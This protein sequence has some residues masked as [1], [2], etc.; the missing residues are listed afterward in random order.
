MSTE[1]YAQAPARPHQKHLFFLRDEKKFGLSTTTSGF[2][3]RVLTNRL[4][5]QSEGTNATACVMKAFYPTYGCCQ[6]SLP[7][8]SLHC[9]DGDVSFVVMSVGCVSFCACWKLP[10]FETT[11][12]LKRPV[13]IVRARAPGLVFYSKKMFRCSTCTCVHY[14]WRKEFSMKWISCEQ[15]SFVCT[16]VPYIHEKG[17]LEQRSETVSFPCQ[18]QDCACSR[19]ELS[20]R[21]ISHPGNNFIPTK[22]LYIRCYRSGGSDPRLCHCP[23]SVVRAIL[24]GAVRTFWYIPSACR[25]TIHR[26]MYG[27]LWSL[28]GVG[29]SP[30]FSSPS[31]IFF[32]AM[33]RYAKPKPRAANHRMVKEI[34]NFLPDPKNNKRKSGEPKRK[35]DKQGKI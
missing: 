6:M 13:R 35:K 26:R 4:K 9:C 28:S 18:T 3:F 11:R 29:G 24:I 16:K 34:G 10:F 8:C 7:S 31:H 27:V 22:L 5:E 30:K 17:L 15:N 21:W 12:G 32:H 1:K 19:Q 23:G 20:T 33:V 25:T 14:L 2:Q